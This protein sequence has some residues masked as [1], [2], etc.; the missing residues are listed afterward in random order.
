MINKYW[1]TSA[2]SGTSKNDQKLP[3]TTRS[4]IN[5]NIKETNGKTPLTFEKGKVFE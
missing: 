1:N 4:L 3:G 5:S 2:G